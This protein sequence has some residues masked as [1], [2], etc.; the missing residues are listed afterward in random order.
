MKSNQIYMS[1]NLKDKEKHVLIS[2]TN[3]F[4][5]FT[6]KNH[7]NEIHQLKKEINDIDNINKEIIKKNNNLEDLFNE[8]KN[9]MELDIQN[10]YKQLQII[11]SNLEKE[12]IYEN[13]I[14]EILELSKKY[15]NE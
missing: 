14:L 2:K 7:E 6:N 9:K 5:F 12:N 15:N 11:S 3:S 4:S 1:I 13:F 8:Y 10:V